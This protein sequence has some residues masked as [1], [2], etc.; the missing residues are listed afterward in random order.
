VQYLH[1]RERIHQVV[2]QRDVQD[3]VAWRWLALGVYSASSAY[4]VLNLGQTSLLGA[5]E[6]WKSKALME[7]KFFLWLVLQDSCWTSE[8]LH[9]HGLDNNGPCAFC[10]QS[11]EFI[12][13]LLLYCVFS[14]EVSFKVLRRF[15]WQDLA[16]QNAEG[17]VE[18]WLRGRKRVIK[19]RC[20]AFDS[21]VM[22]VSLSLW[23]SRNACVL[24][25]S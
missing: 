4:A 21:L 12:D 19:A 11:P 15:G 25:N 13:H 8:R 23:L 17:L 5:K 18:W 14:C 16:L 6:V 2:L 24:R 1:L 9:R 7:I 3:S 22:L 20:K 10:S